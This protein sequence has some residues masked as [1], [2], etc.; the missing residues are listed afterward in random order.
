MKSETLGPLH[1]LPV[2]IKDVTP[3]AGIRTTFAS[4]LYQHHIPAEDAEVVRRLKTAGAIAL[5]KTNTPE[6]ACGAHTDSALFG[7]ARNPWNPDLSPA[8]S[9]GGSAIAV[10]TGMVPIA[11]GTD[12]G[13]SVRVP[14]AFCGIVGLRPTPGL[15]PNYPMPLAWDPGQVHGPLARDAEDAALMLDAIGGAS[16]LSPLSA[17]APWRSALAELERRGDA[18]GLR[19]A[20]AAEIAGIGVKPEIASICRDAALALRKEGTQVEEIDF[21]AGDGRAPYQ[22]WRGFWMVGQQYER[23]KQ[24]DEF[25]RN[26]KGSVEAGLKLTALDLAAAEQKRQEIF[27]RFR[28]LFERFDVLVTPAAPVKPFPVEMSFPDRVNGRPLENYIDWIAPAFL[29]TLVSLPA[30]TAPAGLMRDQLPACR[31]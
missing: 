6:F 21:D 2:A 10:A 24:I 12:F 3:T 11:Q 31:S 29:I 28:C 15:T 1:G 8:G 9:S 27:H 7:P 5:A 16:R 14:A 19:V 18:K 23:L 25:G 26:L 20:Y 22:T 30:A 17:V 13:G 4:P